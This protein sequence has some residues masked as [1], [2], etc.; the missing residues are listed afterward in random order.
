M[1]KVKTVCTGTITPEFMEKLKDYCDITMGGYALTGLNTMPE[2]ELIALLEGAEI[3]II[4]YESVT[5][6]VIENS[7]SLRLIVC[8]RGK[9]VNIDCEAAAEHGIPVVNTP[10]R[11]ANSVAE[12]VVSQ[13]ISVCRQLGCANFE[14]K[15]G[16]YLGDPVE[17]VYAPTE[18]DDVVWMLDEEDNPYKCY[19][20][21][22]ISYRTMGFI[23]FGAI[24]ARVKHLLSG[25]D[26][27]FLVYDPYLPE[28]VAE[29]EGVTLCSMEE[30]L[31]NSDFVSVHCAVTPQTTGMIGAEQFDMMKP[32]A[33]FINTARGKIVR[34][35]DLVEALENGKIAGAVLDVF[36]SEPLPANHPL[37]KMRNVLITPHIAGA[38]N[39]VPACQSRMVFKDILH[40]INR[41]PMEHV[42]NRALLKA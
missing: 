2:D 9:P 10:A 3:A 16:R 30:V 1:D 31:K 29:K 28:A 33:Y 36:W 35:K 11:N 39:D 37:L 32:T 8:P 42:Y 22:E 24:G 21:P 6:K 34:Q 17:D 19:R 14:I 7:P 18:R 41:E 15:N 4:E 26:M 23:G 38:S 5:R 12:Y 40:Y 27:N 20:G 13:M 25:F